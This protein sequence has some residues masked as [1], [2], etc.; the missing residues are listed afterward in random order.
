MVAAMV[1]I[2]VL[3]IAIIFQNTM[4][5]RPDENQDWS[6]F[7]EDPNRPRQSE[8]IDTNEPN[9]GLLQNNRNEPDQLAQDSEF[10]LTEE[11]QLQQEAEDLGAINDYILHG[12]NIRGLFGH[13]WL[14]GGILHLVGNLVFLWVFGN[15]VCAKLGNRIYLPLY[16]FFGLFAAVSHLLFNGSPMLGASGAIFGVVGMFLVFFP[17]NEVSCL[18]IWLGVP[19]LFSVSS[20]WVIVMWFVLSD[21][22]GAIFLSGVS[23]V[24]YF[25]HLGGF[26]SGLA[27]GILMLKMKWIEMEEYEK[28]LLQLLSFEKEPETDIIE[29]T[30]DFWNMQMR[31]V[32]AETSKTDTVKPPEPEP[33]FLE[34]VAVEEFIRFYCSCGNKIKMPG[35]HAGKRGKC[36]VCSEKFTVPQESQAEPQAQLT[37]PDFIKFYCSCGK[38]I[39]MQGIHIGKS[40]KCPACSAKFTVPQESQTA[41]SAQQEVA[42][43][44]R[45]YCSCGKKIKMPGIHIGKNGKCP[46]CSAKFTVP[47]ES[48]EQASTQQTTDDLVRFMCACGKRI[49]VSAKLAG[50]M[51]RCPQCRDEIKVPKNSLA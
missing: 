20:Y 36:P 3:Q 13:M 14:H 17:E 7:I 42:P 38:K 24:A 50:K 16:I 32:E 48:Q 26:A 41:P 15:A 31:V 43:F 28:S 37:V 5:I 47:Q 4:Q 22:V 33:L 46:A 49:K 44:I 21:I 2:F 45:F 19:K 10:G 23:S 30:E 40:G 27:I 51:G 39:K 34:P 18:G 6:F 35:I 25:A 29:N 9:Q 1:F 11:Q 8:Q 12:W